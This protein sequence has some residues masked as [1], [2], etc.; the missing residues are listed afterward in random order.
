MSKWLDLT[1]EQRLWTIRNDNLNIADSPDEI[2]CPWCDETQG[3]EGEDVGYEDDRNTD[4]KCGDCDKNFTVQA[5][6][7]YD[8]RTRLPEEYLVEQ[9]KIE[10]K[11]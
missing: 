10:V 3:F 5:V 1:E 4:H 6:V 11:S 9:A 8:W 2:T 7:T